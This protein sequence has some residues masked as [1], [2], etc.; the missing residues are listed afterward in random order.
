MY[1]MLKNRLPQRTNKNYVKWRMTT[2]KNKS[3]ELH[4]LLKSWMGGGKHNDY[5]LAEITHDKHQQIH[6][7]KGITDQEFTELFIE[8]LDYIFQYIEELE[9]KLNDRNTI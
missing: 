2:K 8:S 1:K 7:G 9:T 3:S 4:H 5:L 6:Y